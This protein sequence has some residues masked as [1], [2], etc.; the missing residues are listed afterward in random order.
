MRGYPPSLVPLLAGLAERAGPGAGEQGDITAVM[1]VL[2]AGSDMEEPVADTLRGLLDGHVV[3]SRRIAER[4]RFPAVD[5]LQSVSR[6]LPDAA[7]G[8]ENALIAEARR[9]LGLYEESELM[10]RS[11]LYQ[12]G[13]SAE[14]DRAVAA[15]PAID[16][17]LAAPAGETIAESF[18]AL[19]RAVAETAED[20]PSA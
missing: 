5:L 3:L 13:A 12:P 11:G 19:R 20:C 16:R 2:V 14:L 10:I 7:S 17:F 18:E 4:G 1:T 6:A 15:F 8:P 9:L